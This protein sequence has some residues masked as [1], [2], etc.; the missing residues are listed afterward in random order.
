M[1]KVLVKELQPIP[2]VALRTCGTTALQN[3]EKKEISKYLH[4]TG[5][6]TGVAKC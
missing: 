3:Q 2:Q 4:L 1:A 6:L 5:E